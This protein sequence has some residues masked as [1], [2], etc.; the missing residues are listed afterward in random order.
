MTWPCSRGRCLPRYGGPAWPVGGL[1]VETLLDYQRFGDVGGW[2]SSLCMPDM[3]WFQWLGEVNGFSS[4]P[5]VIAPKTSILGPTVHHGEGCASCPRK[6][7]SGAPPCRS[8]RMRQMRWVEEYTQLLNT[9]GGIG[10]NAIVP[11]L[12]L[13]ECTFVPLSC[14]HGWLGTWI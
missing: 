7:D 8:G 10:E 12:D 9:F 6:C 14:Y 3:V 1:A 13:Y 11:H 2:V 5:H 4:T